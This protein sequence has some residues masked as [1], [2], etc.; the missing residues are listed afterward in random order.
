MLK[1]ED[2]SAV[3]DPRV[4]SRAD[5]TE[6]YRGRVNSQVVAKEGPELTPLN[7]Q[8]EAIHH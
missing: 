7:V 8:T 5:K 2:V 6:A 1:T 3:S 4:P